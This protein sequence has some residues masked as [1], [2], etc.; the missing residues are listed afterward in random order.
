MNLDKTI[1]LVLKTHLFQSQK[2]LT[3]SFYFK[4]FQ[5]LKINNWLQTVVTLNIN[6]KM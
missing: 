5:S 3:G 6:L 4:V 2:Y 1:I